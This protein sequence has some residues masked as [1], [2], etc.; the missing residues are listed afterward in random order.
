MFGGQVAGQALIAAGRTVGGPERAL[1]ARLLHPS[2]RPRR[3]DRLSGGPPRDGGRSLPVGC[4]RSNTGRRSSPCLGLP[5]PEHGPDHTDPMPTFPRRRS[6]S[7]PADRWPP[8]TARGPPVRRDRP[9]PAVD[10]APAGRGLGEPKVRPEDLVWLR[11]TGTA[12]RPTAARVHDGVRV[13]HDAA[14]FDPGSGTV[15][16]GGTAAAR[17]RL[18]HAMWFHRPTRA[19]RWVLYAQE[20]PVAYG[21]RRAW[22]AAGCSPA[23]RTRGLRGAGGP[24]PYRPRPRADTPK[25][26]KSQVK[27]VLPHREEAG[28]RLP[29]CPW[30]S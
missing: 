5:P 28:F 4:P 13:G 16:P 7:E 2:G 29:T 11:L 20:P 10:R 1:A 17:A 6:S 19:D 8:C 12:R 15:C 9:R 21:A 22:P 30:A 23:G 27:K 14:R 18:D 25:V 26:T 3:A 24:D